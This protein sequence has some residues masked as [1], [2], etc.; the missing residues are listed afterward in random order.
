M[1]LFLIS[2]IVQTWTGWMEF[3]SEEKSHGQV[4][5]IFGADGYVWVWARA[6]FE[7]WQSEFLQL[8]TFVVL[9]TFLI[10]K[11]SHE[12]RDTDDEMTAALE[13]IEKKINQLSKS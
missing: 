13:R 5:Q 1:A 4:A 11:G 2:L 7:N 3:V 9:T 8:F 12:S 10:H 6:T